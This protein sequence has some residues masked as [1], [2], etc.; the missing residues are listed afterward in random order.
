MFNSVLRCKAASFFLAVILQVWRKMRRKSTP[1]IYHYNLLLRAARDCGL[2][3]SDYANQLIGGSTSHRKLPEKDSSPPSHKSD[4]VQHLAGDESSEISRLLPARIALDSG[5]DMHLNEC[6]ETDS[7]KTIKDKVSDL[8]N[9]GNSLSKLVRVDKENLLPEASQS[10]SILGD[11]ASPGPSIFD[12]NVPN[13]LNPRGIGRHQIVSLG[14]LQTPQS[15][16]ALLGGVP[17]ILSH[18]K[19]DKAGPDIK[20]FSQMLDM[21]PPVAEAEEDLLAVMNTHGVRPDE[22]LLH[23]LIRRRCNRRDLESAKV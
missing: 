9:K 20:T 8:E 18:M 5:E 13:I 15:R 10:V 23:S 17:G 1:N 12:M 11:A 3:E 22:D 2:G 16:L 4:K 14:N 21:I 7:V 6:I 19:R